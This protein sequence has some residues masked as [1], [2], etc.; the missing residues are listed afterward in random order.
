MF[1]HN[2]LQRKSFFGSVRKLSAL[3]LRALTFC[4][5]NGGQ[6]LHPRTDM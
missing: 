3:F 1:R 4:P 5:K 2:V 6:L